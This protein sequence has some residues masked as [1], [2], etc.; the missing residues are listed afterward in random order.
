[1]AT[2]AQVDALKARL[3]EIQRRIEFEQSLVN[4]AR[5]NLQAAEE[6]ADRLNDAAARSNFT[7]PAQQAQYDAMRS[8]PN[9]GSSS[10]KFGIWFSQRGSM[11]N[12]PDAPRGSLTVKGWREWMGHRK[13]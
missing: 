8:Q 6:E 12:C 11:V 1:M 9:H 2:Q 3:A 13:L 10:L 4:T 7:L 5:A